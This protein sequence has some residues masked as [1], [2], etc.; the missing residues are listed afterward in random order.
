MG[1]EN[2]WCKAAKSY[3]LAMN[4]MP[5]VITYKKFVLPQC[6]VIIGGNPIHFHPFDHN[7]NV[8]LPHADLRLQ[9]LSSHQFSEIMRSRFA[10]WW[11]DGNEE[12]SFVNRNPLVHVHKKFKYVDQTCLANRGSL[13]KLRHYQISYSNYE[14]AIL[15]KDLIDML[16]G[17]QL[18][19]WR[20]I[21]QGVL[22]KTNIEIVISHSSNDISWSNMYSN[23]RTVY[24]KSIEQ[25]SF[26]AVDPIYQLPNVGHHTYTYLYH[27]VSHYDALAEVTVFSSD[28]PPIRAPFGINTTL[29]CLMANSSFHDFVLN[30]Q[31]HFPFTSALS[32]RSSAQIIRT[33]F[34]KG[35]RNREDALVQSCPIPTLDHSGEY[36]DRIKSENQFSQSLRL[37]CKADK[38]CSLKKYWRK[39]VKLPMPPND[40]IFIN[41][42]GVYAVTREQIRKRSKRDYLDLLEEASKNHNPIMSYI[43]EWFWYYIVTSNISPC[44]T[45]GKEFD[46]DKN[47]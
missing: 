37:L 29:G 14:T 24:D 32:M 44:K 30:P 27:I 17:Q 36:E 41:Q 10:R 26:I 12:G 3:F 45:S 21:M 34:T 39:L 38:D 1:F 42:G 23:I 20:D 13:N 43:L 31:G 8:L 40:I 25:S 47:H 7:K 22:T 11:I 18:E 4:N 33:G 16:T 46:W 28:A 19:R 9:I 6:A 2:I 35:I 5:L 15:K